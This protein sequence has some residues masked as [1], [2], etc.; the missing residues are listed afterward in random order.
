MTSDDD[1]LSV[2]SYVDVDYGDCLEIRR[3]I[4][5]NDPNLMS[6]VIVYGGIY[7]LDGD[8]WAGLG[9]DEILAGIRI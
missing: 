8:C 2:E 4:V 7:P 3:Q 9:L 1:E 6:L 5:D